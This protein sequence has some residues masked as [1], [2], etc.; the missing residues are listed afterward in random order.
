MFELTSPRHTIIVR[1]Q[2]ARL[3]L[4]GCRDLVTLTELHPAEVA[5]EH[6]WRASEEV[7]IWRLVGIGHVDDR[8]LSPELVKKAAAALD[9]VTHE[10]FVICDAQF[11]RVKVKSPGYVEAS[12]LFPLCPAKRGGITSKHLLHVIRSG[13]AAEF[14]V[15]C[16]KYREELQRVQLLYD[17]FV[18]LAEQTYARLSGLACQKDFARQA[19]LEPFSAC[20]FDM[21][22]RG[23]AAR[24]WAQ[25]ARPKLLE[26][27]VF[28][29]ESSDLA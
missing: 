9:P 25:A 14:A 24:E 2:E 4:V 26:K 11:R 15:Y 23:V 5:A 10:G 18:R 19:C 12:W 8:T 16:P 27:L 13:N 6:G 7:D 17:E 22:N 29:D 21:R 3:T 20:L 1:Y 28:K